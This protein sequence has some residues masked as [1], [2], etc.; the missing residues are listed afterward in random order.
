MRTMRRAGVAA[1][2]GGPP[3]GRSATAIAPVAVCR[4]RAPQPWRRLMPDLVLPRV[5]HLSAWDGPTLHVLEW[6]APD[7]ATGL[8]LLCLPGIVRT[9]ADFAV[10][11]AG[12]GAGRRVVAV[13]YAGRGGSFR[14]PAG[15]A[16]ARYGPEA[17]LRDVMDVAAALH[18][19]RAVV[20][21]TSFGGLLAMGLA[22]ARPGLLAA[23][24]LNDIGPEV[25][26]GGAEF[27]RQFVATDPA[28]P[29]LDACVAYLR[30]L[31]PPLSLAD[32][33][34]WRAMA[35]L[36]YA[37]GADQR[38]HP[39]WDTRIAALLDA[40]T[41]DLWPLFRA[42][43][44]VPLLLVHG[45]VS[46]ILTGETVVRMEAAR[47]EAGAALRLVRVPGVGHAPTLAEPEVVAALGAFLAEVAPP[48]SG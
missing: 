6:P 46:D 37:P 40:P 7:G 29:D 32:E 25:G 1:A 13:D 33:A 14:L 35:A 16:P 9:A 39:L 41:P 45:T 22:A 2:A 19:H 24:V 42:L 43:A 20:V 26:A 36:T 8:P 21:G 4:P 47:L 48:G 34:A 12:V 28:L 11:A 30:G 18:L 10:L 44:S 27:V 31:L 15:A 17:C 5:H 38:W 3:G 23:V